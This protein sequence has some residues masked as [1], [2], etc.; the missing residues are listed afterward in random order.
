M[1]SEL[2]THIISFDVPFPADYGGV[3]DVFYKLKALQA[4]GVKIHLHCFEYGR[5][6]QQEIHRYCEEVYYYSRQNAKSMLFN[7]LPYIVLS[8]QSEELKRR[9][10]KDN[11]PILFEGLHSTFYLP[12]ADLASRH[13]V[14][15]TH[16]IEHDYYESLAAV[17]KNIFKR[18]YFFNEAGKLKKYQN[19][20]KNSQGIAAISPNDA[21]YF[22]SQF[23]GVSFIPAFHPYDQVDI[24][25]GKGEFAF[26]HG[27]LGVGEN[28][29][30]ALF[31]VRKVFNDL[32][33]QLII[34]GTKPSEELKKAVKENKN[35]TLFSDRSPEEIREMIAN[36]QCNILPTFQA[37]GIKL[38][39]LAALFGGRHCIV[40][41]PMV[42]NT[43]LE[44]LCTIADS[45]EEMKNALNNIMNLSA[46]SDTGKRVE[47]L[48]NNFSNKG[49]ANKLKRLLFP[50]IQD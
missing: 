9:L 3:I 21:Q 31:L 40:N 8:R 26:Y 1:S 5:P 46:F 36:A 43:G 34:A 30:A 49:N 14:V 22:S 10:L 20:L 42:V 23:L 29:E 47:V 45:P 27:N 37:T 24:R 33:F 19:V 44:S 16:N 28:N 41:S 12:D 39:L 7:T 6:P 48:E 2:H 35:V 4:A 17:E 32:P 11:Y 25:P 13:K 15:R 38:K 50:G 18:Y